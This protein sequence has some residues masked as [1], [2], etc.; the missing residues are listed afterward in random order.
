[1]RGVG[2]NLAENDEVEEH[3][4]DEFAELRFGLS[5]FLDRKH[6]AHDLLH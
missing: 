3:L 1:M 6:L 4:S 2:Q 5:F